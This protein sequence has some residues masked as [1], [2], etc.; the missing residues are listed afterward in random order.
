MAQILH[1]P[2]RKLRYQKE[3]LPWGTAD[4]GENPTALLSP[5]AKFIHLYSLCVSRA[6]NGMIKSHLI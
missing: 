5:F 3:T 6:I 2:A 1:I 4:T